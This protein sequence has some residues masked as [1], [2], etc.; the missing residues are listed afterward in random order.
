MRR[1]ISRPVPSLDP[2]GCDLAGWLAVWLSGWLSRLS[3][4]AGRSNGNEGGVPSAATLH[5][6]L[7]HGL[8]VLSEQ[9]FLISFK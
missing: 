8:F 1:E 3:C 6:A 4:L 7:C 5:S 9:H 2:V